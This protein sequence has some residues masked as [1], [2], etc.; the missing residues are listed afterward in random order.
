MGR[1]EFTFYYCTQQLHS[2]FGVSECITLSDMTLC[3]KTK[4]ETKKLAKADNLVC[5]YERYHVTGNED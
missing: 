2:S 4:S 1:D 5:K 3:I